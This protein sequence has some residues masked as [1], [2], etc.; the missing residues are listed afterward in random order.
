LNI[1]SAVE[2]IVAAALNFPIFKTA[3]KLYSQL[4][5]MKFMKGKKR[6][7]PGNK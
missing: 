3:I 5:S 4:E 6:L 2:V 1:L 7:F